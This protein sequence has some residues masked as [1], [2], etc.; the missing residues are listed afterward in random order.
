MRSL[1]Q[2]AL[3]ILNASSNGTDELGLADAES[4]D[5]DV[6]PRRVLTGSKIFS[7]AVYSL[8]LQRAHQAG[9]G[10]VL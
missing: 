4:D 7:T 3:L 8:W 5:P 1:V 2:S 10:G 9:L 6:S